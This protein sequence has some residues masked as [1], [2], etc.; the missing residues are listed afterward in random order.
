MAE[1]DAAPEPV[2][3][4]APDHEAQ[5]DEDAAVKRR[6]RALKLFVAAAALLILPLLGLAY[7]RMQ[8]RAGGSGE[9]SVA[10]E[11]RSGA[12]PVTPRLSAAPALGVEEKPLV[13]PIK[14]GDAAQ[15]GS[16]GF[17]RGGDDF[18]QPKQPE[19][20]PAVAAAPAAEVQAPAPSPAP[21]PAMPAIPGLSGLPGMPGAPAAPAAKSAAA[22]K[23]AAAPR[24]VARPKLGQMRSLSGR[25]GSLYQAGKTQQKKGEAP[26]APDMT[27]LMKNLPKGIPGVTAGAG[28]GAG[29]GGTPDFSQYLKAAQQAQGAGALPPPPSGN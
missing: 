3:E 4:P 14:E 19:A 16:M 1:N 8:E 9:G 18:A 6:L 21:A 23:K 25:P 24:A 29:A 2:P 10:F 20:A 5:L 13:A 11:S 15:G 26:Q 28:A 27:E 7:L 12:G 17:I 22:P